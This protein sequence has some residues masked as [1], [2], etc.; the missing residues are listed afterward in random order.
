MYHVFFI[1]SSADGHLVCFHV[2]AVINSAAVNIRVHVPFQIMVFPD[3][4]PA[5]KLLD[6]MIVLYLVIEGISILFSIAVI[7][8]YVSTN[9]V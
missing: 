9:S 6:H 8:A 4:C 3:K 7:P 5:M 1:Q 2:L